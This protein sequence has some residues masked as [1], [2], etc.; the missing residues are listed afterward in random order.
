MNIINLDLS[1][2]KSIGLQLLNTLIL[3]WVLKRLLFKPVTEFMN[4]R[5]NDIKNKLKTADDKLEESEK[6][7]KEYEQ[8][9]L[10]I[11]K[12]AEKVLSDSHK[13]AVE[14]EQNIIKK[15]REEAEK[16]KARTQQD[17]EQTKEQIKDDIRKEVVD[18][19][20]LMTKKI[21]KLNLE[22][23]NHLELIDKSIEELGDIEWLA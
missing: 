3:F 15:A 17:I 5:T 22:E 12:E 13:K 7:K 19:S 18:V 4:N 14:E 6:L 8:K 16:I 21:I 20:T 11:N 9:L 23:K 10:D 1:L 2:V